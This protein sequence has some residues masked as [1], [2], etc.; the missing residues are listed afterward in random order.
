MIQFRD[1]QADGYSMTRQATK[2]DLVDM[3]RALGADASDEHTV[4]KIRKLIAGKLPGVKL[5]SSRQA[6]K[7]D[8]LGLARA[9]DVEGVSGST[10]TTELRASIRER[11]T[12]RGLHTWH[13]GEQVETPAG[14][15]TVLEA[16]ARVAVHVAGE[17]RHY[18][19]GELKP[20]PF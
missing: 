3:A 20:A 6:T 12:Q 10:P 11:L 1:K 4:E 13:R 19:P 9:L 15:G 5:D 18:W 7:N 8:L 16:G 14:L 2:T 17:T